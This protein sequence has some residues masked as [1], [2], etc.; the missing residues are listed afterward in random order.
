MHLFTY[1]SLV[2]PEVMS[3]VT[4]R[5]FESCDATLRDHRRRLLHGLIYPGIR[6]A[7]GE[8][9]DGRLY[10]DLDRSALASLDDFEGDEYERRTVVVGVASGLLSAEAYVLGPAHHSLQT[11]SPWDPQRFVA[12]HLRRYVARCRQIRNARRTSF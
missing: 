1:G 6:F 10:L 11:S 12:S 4:G 9:T 7:S 2:F 3:A 8:V 5:T